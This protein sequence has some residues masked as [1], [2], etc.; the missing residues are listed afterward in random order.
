MSTFG[1]T[2][3]VNEYTH[4][5]RDNCHSLI[6]LVLLSDPSLLSFYQTIPPLS[7]SDHLGISVEI[8]LKHANKT[9]RPPQRSIWH[10]SKA[11]WHSACE[12]IEAFDWDA[13]LVE[14]V[15]LSWSTWQL[16]RNVY[17]KKSSIM[18]E[19]TMV[20]QEH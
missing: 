8:K 2:Q 20:E 13:G 4:I 19:S 16:W 9:V 17:P 6:D 5:Y 10:Y 11:D 3:V 1:L 7:N 18:E 15:T 12:R 14:D